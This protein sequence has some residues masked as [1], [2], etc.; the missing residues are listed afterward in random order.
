MKRVPIF[1]LG[2]ALLGQGVSASAQTAPATHPKSQPG[3]AVPRAK[4][5][6]PDKRATF[7]TAFP[8]DTAAF[9]RS[10]RPHDSILNRAQDIPSK[11]SK[12]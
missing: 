6:A 7:A 8:M 2:W 1:L 10:G 9:R 5:A 4:R 12:N 11:K 3:K